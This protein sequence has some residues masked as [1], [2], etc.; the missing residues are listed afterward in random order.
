MNP[1]LAAPAI[2]D[3]EAS[4]FGRGSYPIEVGF[5]LPDGHSFCSL[6]R[7]EPEW[8]AWDRNAER[9]HG[10]SRE[11]LL[12]HGRPVGDIVLLMNERLRGLTVYSDGWACDFVWLNLMFDAAHRV[13]SFRLEHLARLLGEGE[14]NR[15]N[16]VRAEVE[17]ELGL[18]RHRASNDAR[19]LQATWRRIHN[20][21]LPNAA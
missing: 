6:I 1:T 4:G 21:P 5:T 10:I 9:V 12:E 2:I 7:P 15:W 8:V 18:A 13:P 14:A 19:V 17:R 11:M 3:F 20:A 16:D